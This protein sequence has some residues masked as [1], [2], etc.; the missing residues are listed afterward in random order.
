M[1]DMRAMMWCVYQLI[2]KNMKTWKDVYDLIERDNAILRNKEYARLGEIIAN[3]GD[4]HTQEDILDALDTVVTQ[5]S[6]DLEEE[7]D[8]EEVEDAITETCDRATPIYY[9]DIA[10]WFA[11]NWSAVDETREELGE[12][13]ADIMKEIQQAYFYTL[14]RDVRNALQAYIEY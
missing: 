6:V 11:E 7:A 9:A 10:K 2:D 12:T 8:V 3:S 1:R 13:G 4:Y 5:Y 14:E